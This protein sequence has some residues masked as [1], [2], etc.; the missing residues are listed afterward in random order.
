M[1]LSSEID[2]AKNLDTLIFTKEKSELLSTKTEQ[3]EWS[4]WLHA[5]MLKQIGRSKRTVSKILVDITS[6]SD[7]K[8]KPR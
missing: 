2:K 8:R 3:L 1:L 6:S 7:T 4:Y 5:K